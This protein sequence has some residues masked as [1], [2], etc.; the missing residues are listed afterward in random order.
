MIIFYYKICMFTLC[1]IIQNIGWDTW[2]WQNDQ[3]ATV[4]EPDAS[5]EGRCRQNIPPM[6]RRWKITHECGKRK[7]S[8]NDR[9]TDIHDKQGWC[10]DTSCP[11][12]P[13]LQGLL[14]LYPRKL[15]NTQQRLEQQMTWPMIMARQPLGRP[16]SWSSSIRK[17]SRRWWGISRRKG[18]AWKVPQLSGQG[19][20]GCRTIIRMDEAHWT[21]RRTWRTHHSR[22]GSGT[23]HQILQQTYHQARNH[24]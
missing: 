22:T 14:T 15:R 12:T 18:H 5:H 9:T 8:H 24:R 21:Q 11:Q 2:P 6:P 10:P 7:Q 1:T 3:E 4:Y 16:N 19:S 13:E 20:C 17:T 23:E